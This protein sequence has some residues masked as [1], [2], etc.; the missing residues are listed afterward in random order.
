MEPAARAGK[1]DRSLGYCEAHLRPVRR[2]VGDKW[3]GDDGYIYLKPDDE[4]KQVAEHRYVMEKLLGRRLVK[5]ENVHHRNGVRADN[6]V[7]NLELWFVA[8][9]A[10]QRVEELLNYV[11]EIHRLE[12]FNRIRKTAS[13]STLVQ[14]VEIP[15][16]S[17]R[18]AA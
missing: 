11:A 16:V 6:R 12:I 13:E 9:P 2:E 17:L 5:G 1:Q 4:R 3:T 15:E 18:A 10:G 14:V 7:E 8:Q